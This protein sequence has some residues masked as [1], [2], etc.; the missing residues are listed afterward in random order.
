MQYG[1]RYIG[2]GLNPE[3]IRMSD[4]NCTR[5]GTDHPP[6]EGDAVTSPSSLRVCACGRKVHCRGMCRPVLQPRR[7]LK[8]RQ[9]CA[10][11]LGNDQNMMKLSQERINANIERIVAAAIA[12]GTCG[13]DADAEREIWACGGPLKCRRVG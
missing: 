8:H 6:A 12:A 2:S 4:E 3:Y 5:R 11:R 1:R 7:R 9:H 13:V 10:H